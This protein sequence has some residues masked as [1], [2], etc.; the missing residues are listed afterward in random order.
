VPPLYPLPGPRRLRLPQSRLVKVPV[1][2][3][4]VTD[5]T[6]TPGTATVA[7]TGS[8]PGLL[9]D[10]VRTPGTANVTW[11]GSTPAVVIDKT[12]T[13]GTPNVDWTG[14]TPA[15]AI[16]IARTPG[17]AVVAWTGSTPTI[18]GTGDLTLTPGTGVVAWTGSTAP[19]VADITRTPGTPNVAWSGSTPAVTVDKT[20]TPGTATVAWSGSTP[21]VI[22]EGAVT[23]T[24]GTAT[25]A[26]TGSTAPVI[27]TPDVVPVPPDV[28]GGDGGDGF[29]DFSEVDVRSLTLHPGAAVV[30]WTGSRA[31]VRVVPD[32]KPLRIRLPRPRKTAETSPEPDPVV[33]LT[34]RPS[35]ATV[36]WGASEARL[37]IRSFAPVEELEAMKARIAELEREIGGGN[38]HPCRPRRRVACGRAL[39]SPD[40]AVPPL[41]QPPAVAGASGDAPRPRLPG[42]QPAGS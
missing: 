3:T 7:W 18:T 19:T 32:R 25:V 37:V 15:V 12:L 10:A 9:L 30:R 1:A 23:L 4:S 20:L 42:R 29:E 34:L 24:P 5:L 13:P 28:G 16:D 41:E 11:T 14:S 33:D 26:W 40:A 35:A 17:T 21:T 6:L 38:R 36:A 39:H 22:L 8:T 2:D 27:V 31:Y